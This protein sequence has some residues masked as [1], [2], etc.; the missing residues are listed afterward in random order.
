MKTKLLLFLLSLFGA[1]AFAQYTSIP[2]TNFEAKL[3]SLGYDDVADGKVLTAKVNTL[4]SLDLYSANITD[5]TGI[6]AFTGLTTLRLEYNKLTS[7]DLSKN[8]AL[9]TLTLTGNSLTSLDV[10]KNTAL[11]SLSFNSN[12]ISSIDISKNT[13]L[14]SLEC[15]SNQLTSLDVSKNT[16]LT[17]LRCSSN[18]ITSLDISKNTAITH[19]EC[20]NN[21]LSSLNIKNGKNTVFSTIDFSYNNNLSCITVD[22]VAYANTKFNNQSDVSPYFSPYDCATVTMIPD[23]LFEDKL[24]ALGIDKDGK[25]GVVLNSS[26][27]TVTTLDVSNSSLKDLTGIEGFTGLTTLNCSNNLLSRI[28]LSQNK[29]LN[30]LNCTNNPSLTCIQVADIAYATN[31]WVTKKD[32]GAN[33]SLDCRS[34]TLIPDPKFE[35]ALI[36][37]K[38]DDVADGKVL[39]SKINNVTSLYVSFK[40]ITDL[41]GV[42]DFV[43]LQYLYCS[44][45]DLTSLDL[46]KN[47]A[48]TYLSCD[49]NKLAN[50]DLSK[51]TLLSTIICYSNK[52]SSLDVSKNTALRSLNCHTN[53]LS[54]LDISKNTALTSLECSIN[55]LSSL[56]L[57]NGKNT[58]LTT[59]NFNR[60]YSLS[61]ITVDDVAYANSKW[62]DK[63][64]ENATYTLYDCSAITQIPDVQFENKLIA[65]GIDTDGKNGVILNSSIAGLKTLDV[66]NSSITDLTGI[67]QF[68]A[69]ISLNVSNNLLKSIDL[70]QSSNLK[71][72]NCSSNTSLTCIQV[73]D[74][75]YATNNWTTTKDAAANFSLDCRPYTLIPD[76]KFEAR[77][78]ALK[79]DD[80]ADGKVLTSKINVV[81]DINLSS[82]SITNLTGIQDFTSLTRLNIN[83][84]NLSS[85]DISKNKKLTSL[86]CY[87]NKLSSV[88]LSQNTA[89]VSL[90]I[91]SNKIQSIDVS[92]NTLLTSL[93]VYGN[94][95][96]SLDVSKNTV[97]TSLDCSQNTLTSLDLS[98]NTALN[99][100]NCS[101]NP[102][103]KLN[104]KNGNNT[105]LYSGFNF[106]KELSC[107]I[108]DDVAYANT[109]WTAD[110]EFIPLFSPY[111]CSLV[112][113]VPN[114]LFEDKLIAL[115]IDT[116]GKNG[117]VLNSSIEKVTALDVSNSSLTDLTG[118]TGFTALKTLNV[119]GNLITSLDLSLNKALTTLDSSNNTLLTCIQVADI[120]YATANWTVKKDAQANFSLDCRAYTL[121]PD[122]KFE[123]K[124]IELEI[125]DVADG[126]VLTSNISK[127]RTLYLNYSGI[128]DLTGIQDFKALIYLDFPSNNV[129]SVDLSKNTALTS[130][131]CTSNKLTSLDVSKNTA[132]TN[133]DCSNNQLTSLDISKNVA[134]TSLYCSN[135]KITSLDIS[136]NTALSTLN[137]N[138]NQLKLLDV[139][140]NTKLNSLDCRTN[141]IENLDISKNIVLRTLYASSN[142]L[143]S[144]NL[145]NGK[146]TQLS[147]LQFTENP[148]L[149]CVSVD[150]VA[151]ANT[152]WASKKD[153]TAFFTTSD[154]SAITTIP[155]SLFED[156]LISLGIDTDGKNGYVL[157]SAIQTLTSL[158]ISNSSLADVKGLEGFTALKTL[159]VSNNILNELNLSKNNALTT[160]DCSKNASLTCI[161]V[162]DVA[163]AKKWTTTKD[164]YTDFNVDCRKYTAIPDTKFEAQLMSLGLD[165][166]ADGRVLTSNIVNVKDLNLTNTSISDLSGIQ[167]FAAL[168]KLTADNNKLTS[169]DLSKNTLLENLSVNTNTLT[170]LDVNTGLKT[171][172]CIDNQITSLDFSK[173]TQLKTLYC[174]TNKLTSLNLKNGK[175]TLLTSANLSGNPNLSCIQV[176]DVAYATSMWY[177]DSG[178]LFT[179]YDCGT[180]TAIPDAQFENKLIALGI[181]T[182]GKNGIVFNSSI[183][184]LTSLNV[185][186][187]SITNLKGIEGFTALTN[188]ECGTNKLTTLDL[189]KNKALTALTCSQNQL[190]S[191]DLSANTSLTKLNVSSNQLRSLDVSKNIALTSLII[192][193]NKLSSLDLSNNTALSQLS[194]KNNTIKSLDISKNTELSILN[195]SS[196]TITSLDVEKH[197]KLETL[198]C[199]S[200]RLTVLNVSNNTALKVLDFSGNQ[201]KATDISKNK[202]LTQLFCNTNQLTALDISKN[203]ALTDLNCSGNQLKSLNLKNGNNANFNVATIHFEN[204]PSLT[205]IKVDNKTYSDTNWSTL[206]DATANYDTDCGLNL[207]SNNFTVL[208]KGESCLGEN[209]GEITITATQFFNYVASVNG[210]SKTFTDNT[211]ILSGLTPGN[212]NVSVTIPGEVFEQ[213]FNITIAKGTSI[214][215]KSSITSKKVNVEITDGTAPYT[216]LVDGIEQFQTDAPSFSVSAEGAG[217]LEVKTSKEC[218]GTY[219]ENISSLDMAISAYPN[220]T[221]GSFEIELPIA[222]KEVAIEINSLDGRL[223]SNKKYSLE[224]GIARLTLEDQPDGVYIAK[225][226]LGTVK[227]I[228]IIKK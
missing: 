104:L 95:L 46:S 90:S 37:A 206:K 68:K 24:I 116:D 103:T 215:G 172:S 199:S 7:I 125:D 91:S 27:K 156:K 38:Y 211:L 182:D 210:Q 96:S 112:T 97:L 99:Y 100:L 205:C 167:D 18:K 194:Y 212:Y 44:N 193:S 197:T 52:L 147:N 25:N 133:I 131:S 1:N 134:L 101:S 3:I 108:V 8:T 40:S 174:H 189:S 75:A 155:N 81:T 139:S 93:E 31:N 82:S 173:N 157:N 59:L 209:N 216:V 138:T 198:I 9:T 137:C 34:Y 73:A 54:T 87:S 12:K 98:K 111:D 184:T 70:S 94:Q 88:D 203:T 49:Y 152:N 169:L 22:D 63:K 151:Y 79:V 76:T 183:K 159:N 120:A 123:A 208:T 32:A 21:E 148:T 102:L 10:S 142:K 45:N 118:L 50:L 43:K 110:Q 178:A 143:S 17:Y 160:L 175:N 51:N 136:K 33:F 122:T 201:I 84:N 64:N 23:A 121:I 218:E 69:L 14:T 114:A 202:A 146:N 204:N 177:K 227:T 16:A 78:I 71:T 126:R 119:S 47:T 53:N 221:S 60:N 228:K 161:Q 5:L 41:T 185:S 140:K 219:R 15:N 180:I 105:N 213:N 214:T 89:L 162:S 179:T 6:Q 117:V 61:C 224:N 163:A 153:A 4:K 106:N 35:A 29:A 74:I 188:L 80:V 190:T 191:L 42:Q 200:N 187:S 225:I 217:V 67:Q 220:P 165:D 28:D 171:L 30:N 154:C 57:K 150:D 11:V 149:S 26:I 186:N 36:E 55:N 223:I 19:F 192:D 113:P 158:D 2:D 170:K 115:G 66:S 127:V 92:K 141:K 13:I 56:N 195:C 48:L 226:L 168:I 166:I 130:L 86:S 144:L 85:L 207:P 58:S 109:N 128:S 196:N 164:A 145:K 222:Y 72:L 83:F 132:L 62:A 135:N 176:D 20:S 77:L 65:L 181:D 129:T 124:L 39:T 107:V